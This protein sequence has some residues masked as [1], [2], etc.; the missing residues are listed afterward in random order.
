MNFFT[1]L[2]HRDLKVN[3]IEEQI[4]KRQK[5]ILDK[6]RELEKTKKENAFLESVYKDYNKYYNFTLDQKKQQI[7]A[8][9][10]LQKYLTNLRTVDKLAKHEAENLQNDQHDILKE[11]DKVKNELNSLIG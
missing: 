3:D 2:A 6:T 11:L 8:L 4:K 10:I 5:L 1:N 9:D 7:Q